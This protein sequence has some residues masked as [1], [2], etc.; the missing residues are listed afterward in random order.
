MDFLKKIPWSHYLSFVLLGFVVGTIPLVIL[1]SRPAAATYEFDLVQIGRIPLINEDIAQPVQSIQ[2]EVT[3]RQLIVVDVQS[4]AML[5]EKNATESAY[6]ASTTKM[7]TALVAK[8][9]FDLESYLEVQPE[10]LVNGNK[11]GFQIGEKVQVSDLLH[12]ALIAS[13]NEATEILA[14]GANGG[15]EA[16]VNAMNQK[17]RDLHLERTLFINPSGFDNE[18]IYSTA[19]DLSVLAREILQDPYLQEVVKT[20]EYV[21]TNPEETIS[22]YAYNTNELLHT[23]EDVIGVKTG[24]TDGAGQV[25]I[26]AVDHQ[27]DQIII[28]VMGSD[29]RYQDT[30]RIINWIF[31][32]YE[33]VDVDLNNLID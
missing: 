33:W 17:A 10:H 20:K 15:R 30:E 27:G 9:L 1:Y 16:F 13:S 28:V 2:E 8:D 14:G 11:L 32:S 3:A 18:N 24:T 31:D 6:P 25:L 4:G 26:T 29:D 5:L 23:R 21:F 7:M 19:R 22:H 12:S